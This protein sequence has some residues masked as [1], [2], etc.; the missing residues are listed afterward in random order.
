MKKIVIVIISGII[1][2]AG[3]QLIFASQSID[4]DLFNVLAI[5]GTLVFFARTFCGLLGAALMCVATHTAVFQ[6]T[7]I[8]LIRELY[9]YVLGTLPEETEEVGDK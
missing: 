3:A 9:W 6:L 5:D 2:M 4:F 7:G 1:I 8:S